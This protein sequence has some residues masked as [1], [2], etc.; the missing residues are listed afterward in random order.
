MRDLD[1]RGWHG[2]Q[3]IIKSSPLAKAGTPQQV[4][5]E[6]YVNPLQN[7]YPMQDTIFHN[8]GYL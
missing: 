2:P 6:S 8:H 4:A 3:E 7:R 1:H 5:Q